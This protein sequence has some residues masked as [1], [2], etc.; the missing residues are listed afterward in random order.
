MK[1][2]RKISTLLSV[3]LVFFLMAALFFL[4]AVPHLLQLD[5]I[6]Q[7]ILSR[8]SELT[9][10]Q[11][12]YQSIR[13]DY[14]PRPEV[15]FRKA[16][17]NWPHRFEISL[18]ELR[19]FPAVIPLLTGQI[20]LSEIVLQQPQIRLRLPTQQSTG[21]TAA[22][23]WP[24]VEDLHQHVVKLASHPLFQ[25]TGLRYRLFDGSLTLI[26]AVDDSR[27]QFNEIQAQIQRNDE[28]LALQLQCASNLWTH[29]H[30]NGQ[31]ETSGELAAVQ[32]KLKQFH[33]HKAPAFFLPANLP[34]VVGSLFDGAARLQL[35]PRLLQA[36]LHCRRHQL[37]FRNG[38]RQAVFR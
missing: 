7:N 30:V 37:N 32:L 17:L 13:I 8:L 11:I 2:I 29:L 3:G 1:S 38:S 4:M 10:G 14:L 21:S 26:Y 9:G 36:D 31:I 19:A 35:S 27:L 20:E 34:P 25:K 5:P 18:E 28:R 6:K 33:P 15:V 24:S 12:Q 22:A 23:R 16:A